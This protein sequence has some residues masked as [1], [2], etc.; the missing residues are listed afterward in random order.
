MGIIRLKDI[1]KIL[2]VSESTV[3]RALRNHPRISQ[4]TQE[5]VKRLAE[6]LDYTPN[7]MALNLQNKHINAIGVV[8]PKLSYY[9]YAQ[10]ISGM[11]EVAE[12]VGYNIIICQSNESATREKAIV[13][14][15]IGTRIAGFVVSLSSST[16]DFEHLAKIKRRNIPLV[17]FN[18]ECEEIYT[19]RV[20]IDNFGAAKQAV[21]HLI[22][23]GCRRIAYLGGPRNVQISNRRLEGYKAALLE[24]GLPLQ[25]DLILH[26]EF[27]THSA[28]LAA[29]PLLNRPNR[30]DAFLVF[31]DQFA[32]TIYLLA[33]ELGLRI[34]HDI[35]IIGF[36]NEPASE[37]LLPP[38]TTI[39]QPAFE[40]GQ[41]A[42]Q[43]LFHQI[44]HRDTYYRSQTKVLK[45]GLIVR[46]STL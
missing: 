35:S 42:A 7:Q 39:S 27:N 20:I 37:L 16:N 21:E 26:T 32:Y 5:R 45:S 22:R 31:S 29:L 2:E 19:D 1:A 12:K 40:M 46:A 28:R 15:L 8:V 13:Q 4:A 33:R 24:H 23:T 38:L 34:P 3:S 41:T 17:F 10:A 43:L 44:L 14:E 9:L 6:Q 18:R 25:D 36:N 30:P 11:E